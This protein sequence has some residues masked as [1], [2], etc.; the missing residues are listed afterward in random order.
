MNSILIFGQKFV[1]QS[2]NLK[3]PLNNKT[4]VS[5]KQFLSTS[6]LNIVFIKYVFYK[7]FETF[8]WLLQMIFK[9]KNLYLTRFTNVPKYY[10][11]KNT[12]IKNDKTCLYRII[13]VK[14]YW[15]F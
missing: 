7:T 3:T 12:M 6:E 13:T 9:K 10:Y 14:P 8:S 11:K 4:L 2:R 1:Y 15:H 5:P